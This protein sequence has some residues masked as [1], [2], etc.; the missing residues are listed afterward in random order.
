MNDSIENRLKMLE[1]RI[2]VLESVGRTAPTTTGQSR[3]KKQSPK[4]FLIGKAPKS[5]VEKALALGYY[6]EVVLGQGAF[7]ITDLETLFRTAKEKLPANMNDTANKNVKRGL[8][9]EDASKK[10]DKRAWVLTATG[11]KYVEDNFNN[12][13]EK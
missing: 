5:I 10:D 7:N 12:N 4:E 2:A 11:E 3:A 8:I 6:Y 13:K 1:D 9:M